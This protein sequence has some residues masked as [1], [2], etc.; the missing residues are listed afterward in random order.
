MG[1]S[2]RMCVMKRGTRGWWRVA[3]GRVGLP[4]PDTDLGG[5]RASEGV[6]G[7][8][9]SYTTHP[10]DYRVAVPIEDE[11]TGE[12]VAEEDGLCVGREGHGERD[13]WDWTGLRVGREDTRGEK[14]YWKVGSERGGRGALQ[15]GMRAVMAVTMNEKD[16]GAGG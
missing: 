13:P 14:E 5:P 10:Y 4:C 9:P 1:T 15:T 12:L 6:T 3:G 16:V 11:V 2:W 7:V 8:R